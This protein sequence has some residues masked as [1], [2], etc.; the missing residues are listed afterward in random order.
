MIALTW[1]QHRTQLLVGAAALLALAA[2][3]GYGA[4]L[5]DS[6]A[7]S[8][9]LPA[10][11]A[12]HPAGC[13][14]LVQ[15]FTN[16]FGSAPAAFAFLPAVPMLAGLFWGAPL[17]AREVETGTHRMAWT[18]SVSRARWLTVKLVAFLAATVLGAVL[19][20]LVFGWWASIVN[21]L[22]NAGAVSISRLETP[23][24]DLTGI[25]PVGAALFAFA[26]GTAAGALIRR[27]IPAMVVTLGV[28]L[29]ILIPFQSLRYQLFTPLTIAGPFGQVS[30]VQP[31]AYALG[32]G[33]TDA[34]G[35]PVTF[36]QMLQVCGHQVAN[37]QGVTLQCLT[38][39]HFGLS[40]TYLPGSTYWPL[41]FIEAGS[42]TAAA[43]VL[44]VVAVWWTTRRIS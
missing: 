3:L 41:Q 37:G 15:D 42:L 17:V 38:A 32:T 40:Q 44:L 16:H 9:G 6:Y 2:Y 23:R 5:R 18:Q 43:V 24:F 35:H 31:G 25:M 30:P 13:G 34:A 10:C 1:R 29:A 22:N 26:L 14:A 8:L 12:A 20:S 4:A 33:Y 21:Q 7:G 11:I 28:Y 19:V 39:N 36:N 27:T